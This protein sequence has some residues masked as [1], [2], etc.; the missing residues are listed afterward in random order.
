MLTQSEIEVY[1]QQLEGE[2]VK[3]LEEIQKSPDHTDFGSD[4]DHGDEEVD[5][6]E[7]IANALG[8]ED[9][10]KDRVEAIDEALNKITVGTYG[11]C[12][13]CKK[14]ID[15]VVLDVVPE[16]KLCIDCKRKEGE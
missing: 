4:V 5:E 15:K 11:I 1:K 14:P 2:R 9:V 3:L 10:I 13:L 8:V 6:A 16:S 7:E 12:E